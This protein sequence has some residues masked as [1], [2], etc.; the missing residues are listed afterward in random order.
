MIKYSSENKLHRVVAAGLVGALTAVLTIIVAIPI[1]GLQGAYVNLGDAGVYAG[2]AA[3][4]GWGA[5]GAALGSAVADVILGSPIYAPATLVIKALMGLTAAAL[6]RR[7]RSP[8]PAVII[9]GAIMPAGYFIYETA[10]YGAAPALSGVPM[11]LLQWGVGAAIGFAM[12]VALKRAL[13]TA[14]GKSDK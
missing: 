2:A 6:T 1:P 3:L 7:F 10:L 9:A 5:I 4:G 11:N 14:F 13:P 8:L 12:I